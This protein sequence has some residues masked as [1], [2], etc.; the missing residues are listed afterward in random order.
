MRAIADVLAYIRA[1][2]TTLGEGKWIVIQQVFITRLDEKRYPTRSELDSAAPTNPVVFRTGPDAS[3]NSL[4][5][6]HFK[7]TK[8]TAAPDGVKIEHDD[9][10]EPNGILRGWSRMISL[11][12]SGARSPNQEDRAARLKKLFRDYN[13]TGITGIID[14][15]AGSQAMGL[16]EELLDEDELTVRIAMSR[17]VG[18]DGSADSIREQIR[19]IADEPLNRERGPMLRTVGIKMFLDGGMLTGSALMRNP[20]GTSKIYGIDDPDYRGLRFISEEKLAAAVD[21]CVENDMQFTAHSVGDGAVHALL[22][23]YQAA[24]AK[25]PIKQI[26]PNIT[27]CN[28]MSA[29]AVEKMAQLGVSADIQPAWLYLDTRTL[30]SHFGEG[31]ADL[32]PTT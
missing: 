9:A 6:A 18:N 26:R 13:S 28:F 1:R 20:W 12:G 8:G 23:A 16:Y 3:L 22:D 19:A 17:A 4:A 11:P 15:N 31:S 14:R 30:T 7:I 25:R 2:A 29:E 27:H 21:A 5:L 24:A 10:G 32:L